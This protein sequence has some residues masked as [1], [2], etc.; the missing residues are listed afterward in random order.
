MLKH[1]GYIRTDHNRAWRLGYQD[2]LPIAYAEVDG[3]WDGVGFWLVHADLKE[4]EGKV[5]QE[6]LWKYDIET[7]RERLGENV[8]AL[9]NGK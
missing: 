2:T 9:T 6:F 3:G 1:L 4:D 7:Y 5:D 8:V